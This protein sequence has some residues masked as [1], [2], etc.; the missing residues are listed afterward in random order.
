[1]AKILITDD[2]AFSRRILELALKEDGHELLQTSNGEQALQILKRPDAPQLALIDWMMPAM[3]GLEVCRRVRAERPDAHIHIIIVTAKSQKVDIV[4]AL[5]SGAD[6]FI[7]KP[8]NLSELGA[9]VRA[10]LRTIELRNELS[11][12]SATLQNINYIVAHDLRTPLIALSMTARQALDGSY[13]PL[14]DRYKQI[15]ESS[16]NS[17]EHCLNIV[18]SLRTV[19]RYDAGLTVKFERLNLEKLVLSCC[20]SLRPLLDAK[21]LQIAFE[22]Y[23]SDN[24]VSGSKQDLTRVITNLLDNA[25]KYSPEASHLKFRFMKDGAYIKLQI[26]DQ[27][28]GLSIAAQKSLF[29]SFSAENESKKGGGLG[30]GLFLCKQVIE[31]HRGTLSYSQNEDGGCTFTV[32]IPAHEQ[33]A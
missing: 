25:I 22:N 23:S 24:Y 32:A 15:L 9:R 7:T 33:T 28:P 14:P 29:S 1:M 18:E 31:G 26:S 10:G 30:L 5:E 4:T 6:D 3:S 19:T 2:D 8:V 16:I 11:R 13:G 21:Q 17:T 27:G 20:D 12:R